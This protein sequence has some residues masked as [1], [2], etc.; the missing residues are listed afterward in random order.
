MTTQIGFTVLVSLVALQ[1]LAELRVS[2]RNERALRARGA[3]E[4]AP[5]QMPYM[6]AVHTG[7]LVAMLIEVWWLGVRVRGWV[8]L[9]AFAV[10]LVGQALRIAAMRALGGRW[11]VRV[12]TLPEPPVTG[13]VFRHVRHPNYLGVV[14]EIAALPLVHGAYLTALVFSI[15]NAILLTFRIRAE[16]RALAESSDYDERFRGRPRMVPRGT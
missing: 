5:E 3:S 10:F 1:R 7:W 2:R 14:L 11:T 12:L 15:A 8:A 16:E 9:L 13:G 4:H 6:V